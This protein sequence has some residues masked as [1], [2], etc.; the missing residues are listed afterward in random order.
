MTVKLISSALLLTT[1]LLGCTGVP[2]GLKPVSEFDGQRYMGKWYEIARLDHSFE[3]NL[4]N[5]SATYAIDSAGVISVINRGYNEKTGEWKQIE[6]RARFIGDNTVGSLK[7]SFFG[8]FYGGY[9]VIALDKENY[10]YA[11][12]AGPNLSYL[13]ILS[14]STSLDESILSNLT[15]K[16]A[17]WG[18][19]TS[20]PIA[21]RHD[22]DENS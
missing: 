6:G 3:R 7:V 5:V 20:E 14:R 13:W 19:E 1:V 21:I 4:S 2:K 22:R 17:E 16:A 10:S 8:P 18:F 12:V 9:H 15:G 11:M